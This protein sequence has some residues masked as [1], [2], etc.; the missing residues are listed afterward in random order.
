[1]Q[2]RMDRTSFIGGKNPVCDISA[3]GICLLFKKQVPPDSIITLTL[4]CADKSAAVK[5]KVIYS[6]ESKEFYRTGIQF[7]NLTDA[8][9]KE[10]LEISDSYSKGVPVRVSL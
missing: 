10:T 3:T 2:K 7:V 1:M 8:A 6:K 4:K 5:G 9:K